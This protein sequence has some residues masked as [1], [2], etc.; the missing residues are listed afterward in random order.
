MAAVAFDPLG[1]AHDLEATG[2]SREQ[3]EVHVKAMTAM[4]IH[5][6]D[7]LVTTDYLD[8]RF[9]EF[10][11]RVEAN[12]NKQFAAVDTQF[13]QLEATMDKRF[14][15]LESTMDKRFIAVDNQFLELESTM[16]KRIVGL[17]STMDKRFSGVESTMDKRFSGL[18]SAMDKRVNG[19]E[20]TMNVRFAQVST[21][22]RWLK[23]LVVTG[24]AA[25]V[26]P[27]LSRLV[28]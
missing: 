26:W 4:F 24:I 3:A 17:E 12:I 11:T 20:S 25:T 7:A 15:E 28:L 5:N 10:E 2:V 13:V 14:S 6:F 22:L 8:T 1:Y 9:T 16:E 18:G 23:W 27:T 19:L 21:E